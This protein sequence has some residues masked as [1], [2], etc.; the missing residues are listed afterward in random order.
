VLADV[1]LTARW[2]PIVVEVVAGSQQALIRWDAMAL[3]EGPATSYTATVEPGGLSCTATTL[4]ACAVT[5]LASGAYSAVVTAH[6]PTSSAVSDAVVFDIVELTMPSDAP[7]A[8]TPAIALTLLSGGSPV[9]A[10]I[11]DARLTVVGSGFVPGSRVELFVYSDP[12]PLGTTTAD[13]DGSIAAGIVIPADLELGAHTVVARGFSADGL[14]NGYGVAALAVVA[15]ALSSTG[16][17]AVGGLL[18]PLLVI[19]VLLGL[20]AAGI[21]RGRRRTARTTEI[22][23]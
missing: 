21:L 19:L 16:V 15:P 18:V 8:S 4:M 5:G 2:T 13:A 1:V 11:P 14:E 23:G 3:P 10:A 22:G 17:D 9:T 20:G 7:A 6:W 12:E